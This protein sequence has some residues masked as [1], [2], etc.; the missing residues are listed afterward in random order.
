MLVYAY[1]DDLYNNNIKRLVYTHYIH[2]CFT[3]GISRGTDDLHDDDD[4]ALSSS[5]SVYIICTAEK[6]GN[7]Y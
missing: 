5:V 1:F 4:G 6:E 2:D 7:N 3:K